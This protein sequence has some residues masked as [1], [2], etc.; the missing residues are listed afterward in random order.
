M[1]ILLCQISNNLI[2][3]DNDNND[4]SSLYYNTIYKL[5]LED[6]YQRPDDFWEIP[7]WIAQ[8]AYTIPNCELHIVRNIEDSIK[9]INN[10]SYDS[11]I[12]SV[13]NTNKNIID[14]LCSGIDKTV[15][16]GGYTKLEN[17]DAIYIEN[18]NKLCNLIGVPYKFGTDYSM[19]DKNTTIPRLQMSTGC[20][21]HCKFCM[22]DNTVVEV[23][24]DIILQQV[25]SFKKLDFKLI[26]I[27]DKTFGQSSNYRLLK[28]IYKIIKK[29][30][31]IFNGFIV[32]TTGSQIHKINF[33]D[34]HIFACEIG[35]ESYN[36]SILKA[37]KKPVTTKLL[38][39]SVQILKKYNIN[40][41]LNLIIG[42]LG[43]SKQTYTN[44]LNFV[45][46]TCPYSLN[47]YNLAIYDN[48][49]ISEEIVN[50][51]DEDSN[52]LIINRSYNSDA[53]NK[54]NHW[55]NDEIFKTGLAL[56][57]NIKKL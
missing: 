30:N 9:F 36:D 42:L 2:N 1:S 39:E 8:T 31:P 18:I 24:K 51:T 55:F 33:E 16:Y 19:F 46:N 53:I 3:S 7:V 34:L 15:Y 49:E 11:V 43:E 17:T 21:Y 25:E 10:S 38:K 26:Y 20:H 28:D 48:A 12:F 56:L 40:V 47:V 32:Q 14:T 41:I 50:T 6:G 4:I 29:Y 37:F 54:L 45:N 44:T 23:N 52:E 27:D 35:V 57:S 22:I 13:L 5:H